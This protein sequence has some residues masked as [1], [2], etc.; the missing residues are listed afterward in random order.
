[1]LTAVA[2]L[3][4]DFPELGVLVV[5]GEH[6]LEPEYG[7]W[8]RGFARELGLAD[9]VRFTGYQANVAEWMAA[10]DIV[11][12]ASRGEP[13]GMAIVEAMA[14]GKAVVG[15]RDGGPLEIVR[16]GE[17]GLLVP[18]GDSVSL[19]GA[20]R[21]LL[22]DPSERAR[23]G[24]EARRRARAFSPARLA[25]ATATVLRQVVDGGPAGSVEQGWLR[26]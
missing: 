1:M 22:E 7:P 4:A 19:A 15:P 26:S 5:G 16:D 23:L 17:D 24:R 14:L 18:P 12:N 2:D 21:R 8:L 9:R 13:F 10:M 25:E 20:L 3:V 6:P 11:V